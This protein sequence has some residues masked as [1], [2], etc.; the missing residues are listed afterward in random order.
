[1]ASIPKTR[2]QPEE[3]NS[4]R[5]RS[6]GNNA[7]T[8]ISRLPPTRQQMRGPMSGTQHTPHLDGGTTTDSAHTNNANASQ[9]AVR[10]QPIAHLRRIAPL[11]T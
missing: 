8:E 4:K 10:P 1:M 6:C 5:S 9:R 2:D 3:P 7:S 11:G